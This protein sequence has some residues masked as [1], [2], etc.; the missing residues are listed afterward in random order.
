M[1]K[2]TFDCNWELALRAGVG[3]QHNPSGCTGWCPDIDDELV[4][5]RNASVGPRVLQRISKLAENCKNE[6]Q[7]ESMVRRELTPCPRLAHSRL[8]A[9][10]AC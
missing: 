2:I 4:I 6:E 8:F 3:A 10:G 7:L 1:S 5:V 9:E